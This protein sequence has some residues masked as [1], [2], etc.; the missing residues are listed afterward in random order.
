MCI[1]IIYIFSLHTEKHRSFGDVASGK[2]LLISLRTLC[3]CVCACVLMH[4]EGRG[5]LVDQRVCDLYAGSDQTKPF[6]S[7]G[8]TH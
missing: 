5:L 8:N 2:S 6:K 4:A 7:S 3:V 1:H